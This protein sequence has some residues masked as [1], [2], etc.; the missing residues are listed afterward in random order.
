MPGHS[1]E[2][3][4]NL[5]R[6]CYRTHS[7]I[8]ALL[9]V[10]CNQDPGTMATVLTVITRPCCHKSDTPPTIMESADCL[11]LTDELFPHL[12]TGERPLLC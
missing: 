8:E 10:V 4:A 6:Q 5:A 11:T 1:L 9:F 3:M 7:T 12:T 2:T